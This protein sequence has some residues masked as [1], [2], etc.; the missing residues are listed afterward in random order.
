M[1]Q[2][3]ILAAGAL[4]ALEHHVERLAEDHANAQ[5]LAAAVARSR[6]WNSSATR[7]TRIS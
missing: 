3:G 6:A 1:R 2:A 7:S 5:A 4:Y